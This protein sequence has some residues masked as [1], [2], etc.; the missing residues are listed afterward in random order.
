M[1]CSFL[2]IKTPY[3]FA[4]ADRP[5]PRHLLSS[6]S[7]LQ[8]T[9]TGP[10]T[11]LPA[12]PNPP[13]AN[14][15]FTAQSRIENPTFNG[16]VSTSFSTQ[17]PEAPSQQSLP[18]PDTLSTTPLAKPRTTVPTEP[19]IKAPTQ[20]STESRA[21]AAAKTARTPLRQAVN[22]P[23]TALGRQSS[24][25][26][27]NISSASPINK[28]SSVFINEWIDRCD[29]PDNESI[30]PPSTQAE[31]SPLSDNSTNNVYN[32]RQH[33]PFAST[34]YR[35]FTLAPLGIRLLSP[36]DEQIIPNTIQ[37]LINDITRPVPNEENFERAM[38]A[39]HLSII[40]A[41]TI[42]T[43]DM[44]VRLRQAIMQALNMFQ[45]HMLPPLQIDDDTPFR[46]A[47]LLT[48]SMA[49][50]TI[51]SLPKPSKTFG[52][53]SIAFSQEVATIPYINVI[54]DA[55]AINKSPLW[56]PYL[57]VIAKDAE[58]AIYTAENHALSSTAPCI[59]VNRL[60]LTNPEENFVFSLLIYKAIAELSVTYFETS[61]ENNTRFLTKK[62]EVFV[63]ERHD[64]LRSL[65]RHLHHIHNWAH[66]TR[67]AVVR[68]RMQSQPPPQNNPIPG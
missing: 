41:A 26:P 49:P 24:P 27:S 36:R 34:T 53:S 16:R 18:P 50:T 32:E 2:N 64:D 21:T 58:E 39:H 8:G 65:W 48:N 67:L 6:N 59:N 45:I 20:I 17:S 13:T 38:S 63:L 12:P 37:E 9:P 60:V 44:E 33:H 11:R 14:P 23:F 43:G 57:V 19:H 40:D 22:T 47:S 61:P 66:T 25:I 29:D 62:I 4:R 54:K 30:R 35:I 3:L 5:I 46:S 68:H 28:P 52:Y 1:D 31:V 7:V 10:L 51:L 55:L 56:F 42:P 15:N